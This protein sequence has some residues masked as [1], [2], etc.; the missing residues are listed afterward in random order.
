MNKTTEQLR[1]IFSPEGSKLRHDQLALL[2]IIKEFAIICKKHN[3][4]WWLSSGTLLGCLRHNGFI[5]WDDDMDVVMYKSDYERFIQLMKKYESEDYV[6]QCK[7]NDFNYVFLFG[8]F[9]KKNSVVTTFD[10]HLK[11]YKWKGIG[12]DIFAIEHSSYINALLSSKTYSLFRRFMIINNETLRYLT[13]KILQ[14]I[15][16]YIL[17]P[18]Y[19]ILNVFAKKGE[20]HYIQGTGWAR[21][22]FYNNDIDPLTTHYFENFE[23]PIPNNADSYVRR[24]YGDYMK[25]P[26]ID[27]IIN[28]IHCKEYL[29]DIQQDKIK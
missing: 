14:K 10:A 26:N 6:F 24:V 27:K 22:T 11:Y 15:C 13:T 20:Y 18:I 9:R 1:E 4:K 8:K 23:F 7:E 16:F 29:N 3:I 17:F 21:H 25:I 28:S 19:K 12:I 5:P 2:E